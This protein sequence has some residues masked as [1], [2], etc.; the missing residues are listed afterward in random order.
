[1]KT[2]VIVGNAHREGCDRGGWF[3]GYF[4]PFGD[5]P[6]STSAL[7]VKW[8]VHPAGDT[9]EEWG[10]NHLATTLSVLISGRFRLQF[11]DQE[12]VLEKPG[13]YALW[14]PGI[15][16]TYVAEVDSTILSVRYPSVPE[17]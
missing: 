1:M 7:E 9:R 10:V 8:G 17:D 4:M 2:S 16:H 15:A 6:R 3:M 14:P 12:V 13:D 5:D 11:P